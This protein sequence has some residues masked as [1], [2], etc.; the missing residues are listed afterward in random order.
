[1]R[2]SEDDA[3]YCGIDLD[4]DPNL[5]DEAGGFDHNMSSEDYAIIGYSDPFSYKKSC[6]YIIAQGG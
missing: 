5:D 6:W 3:A 1:M 4:L 2:E